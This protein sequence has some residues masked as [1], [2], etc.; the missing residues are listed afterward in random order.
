MR[1]KDHTHE[2]MVGA[3]WI[4]G[5]FIGTWGSQE[6][7]KRCS[8]C[9]QIKIHCVHTW[10]FQRIN[11]NN[12]VFNVALKRGITIERE[13]KV[14]F[15]HRQHHSRHLNDWASQWLC[16][17]DSRSGTSLEN[18]LG[19][20]FELPIPWGHPRD[21]DNYFLIKP[22]PEC[23]VKSFWAP[24]IQARAWEPLEH[25]HQLENLVHGSPD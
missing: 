12:I 6:G 7:L 11:K 3:N 20:F 21:Y 24:I 16:L 23:F 17:E 8:G 4:R 5:L 14:I 15:C 13:E 10:R 19:N 1:T 25:R 18:H 2:H 22:G 9:E